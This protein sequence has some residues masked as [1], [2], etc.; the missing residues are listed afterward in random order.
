MRNLKYFVLTLTILRSVLAVTS[1]TSPYASTVWVPGSQAK[2]TWVGQSSGK[3]TLNLYEGPTPENLQKKRVLATDI[4]PSNFSAIVQVPSD[5]EFKNT[6]A[7][8][9]YDCGTEGTAFSHY[10]TVS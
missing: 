6:Y 9:I 2:I 7:V 1:V 8:G 5:L 10:F 4:D 3:L